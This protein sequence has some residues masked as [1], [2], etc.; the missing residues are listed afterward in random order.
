MSVRLNSGDELFLP[1][2]FAVD[3]GLDR[4]SAAAYFALVR[5]FVVVMLQPFIEIGLQRFDGFIE[6]F[7]ERDLIKFLQDRLVEPFADA[8][9]LRRFHL[10]LGVVDVVDRQE[11]SVIVLLGLAAIFR[12]PVG[13]DT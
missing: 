13:A 9:R 6:L 7:A 4:R 5:A 2:L 8:V 12:S 10:G 11:Q 1:D 3:H